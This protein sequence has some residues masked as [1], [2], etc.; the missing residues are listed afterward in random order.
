ME[1]KLL[2]SNLSNC[3]ADF[4]ISKNIIN[5]NE[6]EAYKF[7]VEL[8]L[9]DIFTFSLIIII[10]A[11]IWSI[12]CGIEFL[13]VFCCARIYCGGYHA[14]KAWLCRL[15]MI[16]TFII[17]NLTDLLFRLKPEE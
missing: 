8:I 1:D 12:R 11:I 15:T 9:N 14:P 6:K 16:T 4:Y 3:I 7:G 10:S 13:L 5:I 17:T 2:I